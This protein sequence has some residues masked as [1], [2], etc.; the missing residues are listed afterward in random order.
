MLALTVCMIEDKHYVINYS[1]SIKSDST[2]KLYQL[3]PPIKNRVYN[4]RHKRTYHTPAANT[5]RFKRTFVPSMSN[6]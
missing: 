5:N 3:L 4:L 2:N 1:Q 6:F